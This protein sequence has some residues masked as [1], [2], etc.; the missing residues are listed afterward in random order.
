[1]ATRIEFVP[2]NSHL[3][4]LDVKSL[5]TSIPNAEGIKAVKKSLDNHP[6]RTVAI[7]V[8]TTFLASI[9]RLNNFIFNYTNYLKPKGCAI[10]TICAPLYAN[11]FMDHFEKNLIYPLI[12]GFS[13]I[14]LRFIDDIFFIW[15]GNKKDLM[16]FLNELN[17]KHESIQSEY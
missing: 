9:L 10:G 1:M 6:K 13:L 4:S 12:K 8:I 2:D 11:I 15:T 7:K 17:S 14:Y 16:N 5:Y 3:V